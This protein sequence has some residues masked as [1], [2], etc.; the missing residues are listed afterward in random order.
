[1]RAI[2]TRTALRLPGMSRER[3]GAGLIDAAG[4]VRAA[5][6]TQSMLKSS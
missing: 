6:A 3:Q 1:V 5:L 2:L 4:A